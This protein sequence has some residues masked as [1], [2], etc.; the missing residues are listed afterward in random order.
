M[1]LK[2]TYECGHGA[3]GARCGE[4]CGRSGRRCESSPR[5]RRSNGVNGTGQKG[6]RL[7]ETGRASGT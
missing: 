4:S 3:R 7:K 5:P 2:K 6:L 1:Q